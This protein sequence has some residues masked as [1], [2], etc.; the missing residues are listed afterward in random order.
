MQLHVNLG[1]LGVSY[2]PVKRKLL[3][4][5]SI[6]IVDHH[7]GKN[8]KQSGANPGKSVFLKWG[9]DDDEIGLP[10]SIQ[11]TSIK[12]TCC[13]GSHHRQGHIITQPLD[14]LLTIFLTAR[15]TI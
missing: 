9:K 5:I 15:N 6:P 13:G 12:A 1:Q 11:M 7:D 3:Q 4:N 10:L 14:I 2:H 8:G